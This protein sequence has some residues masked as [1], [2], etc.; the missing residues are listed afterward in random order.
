MEGKSRTQRI[1]ECKTAEKNIHLAG[2]EPSG[3][4]AANDL[5]VHG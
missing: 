3:N 5:H 2:Y 4:N 1:D